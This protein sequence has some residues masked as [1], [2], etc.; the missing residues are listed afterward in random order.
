MA[1]DEERA[2]ERAV[3]YMWEMLR[4]FDGLQ[5]PPKGVHGRVTLRVAHPF[6]GAWTD[7]AG[8][9]VIY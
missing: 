5:W 6:I 3:A 4:T 7:A 8:H 9:G 2:G 1:D